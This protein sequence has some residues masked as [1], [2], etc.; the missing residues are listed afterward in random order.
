MNS[1]E[2]I[3]L[4]NVSKVY[5]TRSHDYTAV[6]DINFYAKEGTM[7]L[8]LGPSGSG[9]TTLLTMMAGFLKP[10]S[11]EVY[12]FGKN[13]NSYSPKELQRIR[14]EKIGFVFQS[15]LLIDA[16]TVYENVNLVNNFLRNS[17][18][19]EKKKIEESLEKV[20][21]AHLAKK[22][23]VELSHGERQR[24]AIARALVNSADLFIADEP[25]ASVEAEQGENIIKILHSVTK[26]NNSCVLI[27]SHDKRLTRLIDKSI[28]LENG[29]L[30]EGCLT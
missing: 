13:I 21:I 17:S 30:K 16:L 25:T 1:N 10:T 19:K 26:E 27:A 23:P 11:G 28:L 8:L 3:R 24:T 4:V 6:K 29:I 22:R 20:G 9:K 2:V 14:R 15:F 7:T 12:L 5:S 18:H